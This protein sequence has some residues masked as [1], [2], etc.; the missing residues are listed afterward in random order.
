MTPPALGDGLELGDRDMDAD[1]DALSDADGEELSELDG[2]GLLLTEADSLLIISRTANV[3]M[4]RSSLVP[5]VPP[6][7]LLPCPAVV[8]LNPTKH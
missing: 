6:T 1:A 5:F 7:G 8:S 3:T 2:L 4:A